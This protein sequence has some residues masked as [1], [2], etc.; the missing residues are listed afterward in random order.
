MAR[1]A[2]SARPPAASFEPKASMEGHAAFT[3]V[4]RAASPAARAI[5]ART[6]SGNVAELSAAGMVL[7]TPGLLRHDKD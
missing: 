3:L 1:S 6:A 4:S 2:L 7:N 5:I